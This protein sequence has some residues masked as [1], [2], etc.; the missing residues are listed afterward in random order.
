MSWVNP[1]QT[2]RH[3]TDPMEKY[4]FLTALHDRN[5]TLFYRVLMEHL[6]E[7]TPILY[8][9][10]VGLACQHFGHLYRKNHGLYISLQE[11][12]HIAKALDHWPND[13]VD[14]IVINQCNIADA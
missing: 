11:K 13:D 5:V 8:T 12:G 4:I 6:I 1:D 10:T 9:P 3:K 14:I 7:M 2:Y